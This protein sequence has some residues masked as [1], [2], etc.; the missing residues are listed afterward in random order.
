MVKEAEEL[1]DSL[2]E[3]NEAAW[4]LF[5]ISSDPRITRV[6]KVLRKTSLDELP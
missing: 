5:K 6:G 4:P 2:R 3:K 1:K